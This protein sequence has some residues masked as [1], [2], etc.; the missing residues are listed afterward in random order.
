MDPG[1]LQSYSPPS[2]APGVYRGCCWREGK[3]ERRTIPAKEPAEAQLYT[4]MDKGFPMGVLSS[5]QE[6]QKKDAQRMNK[7]LQSALEGEG[8]EENG[9]RRCG[10]ESWGSS[11]WD[12]MVREGQNGDQDGPVSHWAVAK[13]PTREEAEGKTAGLP[14]AIYLFYHSLLV[15]SSLSIWLTKMEYII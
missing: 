3:G 8:S 11:V 2:L 10:G 7:R 12:S 15:L 13:A 4:D 6:K 9:R 14:S 1:R 5:G